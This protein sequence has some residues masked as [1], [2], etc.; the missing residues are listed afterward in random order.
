MHEHHSYLWVQHLLNTK[1]ETTVSRDMYEM[2]CRVVFHPPSLEIVP[3]YR[4]AFV[5][6]ATKLPIL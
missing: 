3:S 2:L 1:S 5:S 4:V 6:F